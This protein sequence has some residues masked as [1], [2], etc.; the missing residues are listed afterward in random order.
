MPDGQEIGG[1]PQDAHMAYQRAIAQRIKS[2]EQAARRQRIINGRDIVYAKATDRKDEDEL[3][4]QLR[5]KVCGLIYNHC[6]EDCKSLNDMIKHQYPTEHDKKKAA[7]ILRKIAYHQCKIIETIVQ[8]LY[9][10][11]VGSQLKTFYDA[12][13]A[14]R[15]EPLE[16]NEWRNYHLHSINSLP[17]RLRRSLPKYVKWGLMKNRDEFKPV[18]EAWDPELFLDWFKLKEYGSFDISFVR[19]D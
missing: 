15:Q 11:A 9:L 17:A 5:V 10:E 19:F 2:E 16:S 6:E 4:K 13:L 18:Y 1:T 12:H 7:E 3:Q 14:P 8:K